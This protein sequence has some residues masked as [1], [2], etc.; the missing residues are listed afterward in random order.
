MAYL[1]HLIGRA[2]IA[3][4]LGLPVLWYYCKSRR[5]TRLEKSLKVVLTFAAVGFLMTWMLFA[6]HGIA[7][8]MNVHLS[9]DLLAYLC[10]TS[11][12][13]LGLDS[14]SFIVGMLGWLI[15]SLTN[16]ALYSII[17]IVVGAVLLPFWKIEAPTQ[18]SKRAS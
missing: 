2:T 18:T 11:I 10:P 5:L 13:A 15:I 14:A 6:L 7:S 9:S 1:V 16:A 8:H 4:A 17:G 3:L 12:V